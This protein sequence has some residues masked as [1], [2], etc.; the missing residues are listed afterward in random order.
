MNSGLTEAEK[1]EKLDKLLDKRHQELVK[2]LGDQVDE[3]LL[4]ALG[5]Q[6]NS[7]RQFRKDECELVGTLTG[8]GGS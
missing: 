3:R 6:E 7:W 1:L 5:A 2:A 4:S 8:A